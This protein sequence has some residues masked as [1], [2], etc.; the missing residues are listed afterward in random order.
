MEYGD[1]SKEK[2]I[3]AI[4]TLTLKNLNFSSQFRSLNAFSLVLNS[5][6]AIALEIDASSEIAL[7]FVAD[8]SK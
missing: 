1:F 3:S 2:A 6:L 5:F 4:F 7:E 8:F